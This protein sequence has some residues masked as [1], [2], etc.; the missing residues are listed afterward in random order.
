M[1]LVAL[2]ISSSVVH[3]HPDRQRLNAPVGNVKDSATLAMITFAVGPFRGLIAD[4]LWWRAVKKQDEGDYF[5]AIQLASWI[6]QLQPNHSMVWAYHGWNMHSNLVN[7]VHSP[8]EKWKW[9]MS[10][11]NLLRNEGLVANP[12][13]PTIRRELAAIFNMRI[14]R[15]TDQNHMFYKRQW[16][17]HMS[18]YLNTGERRELQ[19][20]AA[21]PATR[22]E[23]LKADKVQEVLDV[24]K[25]L[26]LDLLDRKVISDYGSWSPEQQQAILKQ[27]YQAAGSLIYRFAT[28]KALFEKEHLDVERMLLI[29]RIYGPFDWRLW[30]AYIVYWTADQGF[31]RSA[32][33]IFGSYAGE[34]K[35]TLGLSFRERKNAG[36]DSLAGNLNEDDL[37]STGILGDTFVQQAMIT[38]FSDGKIVWLDENLLLLGNNLKIAESVDSLMHVLMD[39]QKDVFSESLFRNFHVDAALTFY[40]YD[41]EEE[42]R[43]MY[44]VYKKEFMSKKERR[45]S[46][47]ESFI[48]ENAEVLLKQRSST[49]DEVVLN[50]CYQAFA[51]YAF[52]DSYKAKGFERLAVLAWT[53]QQTKAALMANEKPL[54][55]LETYKEKAMLL[56][57]S[58]DSFLPDEVKQKLVKLTGGK[59]DFVIKPKGEKIK[60][61]MHHHGDSPDDSSNEED[62][63]SESKRELMK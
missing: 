5:E 59:S 47:F 54:P 39:K 9:I 62:L 25:K 20:L 33:E 44:E 1:L 14:G 63:D 42:A 45:K 30:H 49:P 50:S 27:E 56:A 19:A 23:L 57:L 21:A 6:T 15:K 4:M 55:P 36:E 7:E 12:G 35:E 18:E 28:R 8:E 48:L 58:S 17:L 13:D 61:F 29:D 38:S 34:A 37:D 43:D 11:V 2:L 41:Y 3:Q 52:G 10:A 16:A 40:N 46:T 32:E 22:E 53:R 31:E 51:W 60:I 26:E 24:A